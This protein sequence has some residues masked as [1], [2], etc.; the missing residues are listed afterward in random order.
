M[1]DKSGRLG[2]FAGHSAETAKEAGQAHADWPPAKGVSYFSFNPAMT[3]TSKGQ[4]LLEALPMDRVLLETD[5]P[6]TRVG[7][8][9]ARPSDLPR[10][11]GHLAAR[12]ALPSDDVIRQVRENQQRLHTSA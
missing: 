7:P 8:R 11:L 9:P 10:M 5:G 12:W 1:N 2:T 6:F 4:T 3:A